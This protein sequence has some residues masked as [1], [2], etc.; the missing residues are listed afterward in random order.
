MLGRDDERRSLEVS[1]QALR[2]AH[3]AAQ[4]RAAE[5]DTLRH[6]FKRGNRYD[7]AGPVCLQLIE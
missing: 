5:V 6:D 4:Q 1:V 3:H 7:R 2:E